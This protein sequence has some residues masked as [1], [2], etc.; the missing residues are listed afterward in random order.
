M[1][2]PSGTVTLLF[3]DVEGSTRLVQQLGD[4]YGYPGERRERIPLTVVLVQPNKVV[5]KVMRHPPPGTWAREP[6]LGSQ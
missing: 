5:V 4:G 2:L 6:R 1:A 3:T